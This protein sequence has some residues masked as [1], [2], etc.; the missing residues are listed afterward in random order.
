MRAIDYWFSHVSGQSNA[1][2][3]FQV[4]A[5]E[6]PPLSSLILDR[7]C[8]FQCQHCI[9][10][11]ES[12]SRSLPEIAEVL[13]VLKQLDNPKVVHEGRQLTAKQLPLLEA[14]SCAGYPIGIIESGTYTK[15]LAE[16][17][18]SKLRFSWVDVSVD[19]PKQ[20]HNLQRNSDRSWDIAVNGVKQARRILNH[21]GKVTSLMTITS[22]NCA[23]VSETGE[24][25]IGRG[26]DE[27]HLTTLSVRNGIEKMRASPAQLEIAL[28]QITN[29]SK[30]HKNTFL[31]IYNLEDMLSLIS[32]FGE[33]SFSTLLKKAK[34]TQNALVL[35]IGFPLFFYPSSIAPSETLVIDADGWWRL[36]YCIK[37]TLKE[38]A[39]GRDSSGQN[40]SVYNVT[41][42][43]EQTDVAET[44]KRVVSS[45]R[46]YYGERQLSEEQKLFKN[47]I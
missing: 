2:E 17:L 10:Q 27:W 47:L 28:H 11:K 29:I 23:H 40:I 30:T 20:I 1:E 22:L 44:Y 31:R 46:M 41:K 32:I 37:Y 24:E 13:H 26:V 8:Q 3:V 19:G 38:L 45:W 25:V 21:S 15:F 43:T 36:P 34:V 9:F 6:L 4:V 18:G 14:I 5:M 39:E 33:R 16:I 42:I 12:S 35:D 7:S